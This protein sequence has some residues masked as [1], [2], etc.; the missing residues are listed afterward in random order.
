MLSGNSKL[1]LRL[2]MSK[3]LMSGITVLYQLKWRAVLPDLER[4]GVFM[5][6]M[7]HALYSKI[8]Y[9]FSCYI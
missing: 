7:F 5:F 6:T 4:G 2:R 8:Q 9:N 3:S 1:G